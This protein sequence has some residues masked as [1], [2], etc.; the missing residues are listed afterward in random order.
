MADAR[1]ATIWLTILADIAFGVRSASFDGLA[2]RV[3]CRNEHPALATWCSFWSEAY[4]IFSNA[5][6]KYCQMHRA[7]SVDQHWLLVGKLQECHMGP[8]GT[9]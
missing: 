7:E 1:L 6:D 5:Q 8:R 2:D 9:P 4:S 3:A